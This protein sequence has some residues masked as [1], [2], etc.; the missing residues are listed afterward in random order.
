MTLY[1]PNGVTN[2]VCWVTVH[3]FT[4]DDIG[5]N[6]YKFYIQNGEPANYFN[7]TNSSGPTLEPSNTSIAFIT[8]NNTEVNIS[9]D[10]EPLTVLVNDTDNVTAGPWNPAG[11]NVTFWISYNES[12]LD[13]GNLT[14]TNSTGHASVEFDPGCSYSVGP[15]TWYA[16][17]T[18][19]YY[20]NNVTPYNL[21]VII[22]SDININLESPLGMEYMNGTNVTVRFNI[23]DDCGNLIDNA[24]VTINMTHEDTEQEFS[25]APVI[26]EEDEGGTA[27]WYNCT[28]NTSGMPP[29]EYTLTITANKTWYNF[30]N[31][32]D[33]YL[34]GFT[35]FFIETRPALSM[36]M[37][38]TSV[39]GFE[40]GG[41]GEHFNFSVLVTDDDGDSV[42]VSLYK[43]TWTGSGWS[44][45]TEVTS[46]LFCQNCNSSLVYY[47]EN[48]ETYN[49]AT[50]LG[51]W[52]FNFTAYDEAN[53]PRAGGATYYTQIMGYNYTVEKDDI[54]IF[55]TAGNGSFVWRNG[56][57]SESLS[58][59]INDTDL[60]DFL[61]FNDID[62][63]GIIWI[64]KNHTDFEV[65]DSTLSTDA[66]GIMSY[67]FNPDG[68][69]ESCD[70]DVGI[71]YWKMG[72]KDHSD[73]KDANSSVYTVEIWSY[74]NGTI[75]SPNGE[76]IRRGIDTV[77]VTFNIFDE[78]GNG[79]SPL[80]TTIIHLINQNEIYNISTGI[81]DHG[82][83][84]Y[85]Y[86]WDTTGK[87]LGEY[88]L[89][90]EVYKDY[91]IGINLSMGDSFFLGSA[92]QLQFPAS[93]WYYSDGDG[94]WGEDW[95][96]R[97]QYRDYEI[98]DTLNLSL[99]K[100]NT[101]NDEW[102]RLMTK[103]YTID[104]TAWSAIQYYEISDFTCGNV[105]PDG[106]ESQ[107][108]F[109]ATDQWG[110]MTESQTVNF[111]I[112]KDN[113]TFVYRA[114]G[115]SDIDREGSDTEMFAVLV[116]DYD[117]SNAPVSEN[118]SGIFWITTDGADYATYYTNETNSSGVLSYYFDPNC[119]FMYGEQHWKAGV[120]S[121]ECYFDINYSEF[122]FTLHGQLKNNILLPAYQHTYNV[123]DPVPIRL[124][125][126]TDCSAEGTVSGAYATIQ[127][128]SPYGSWQ[129]CTPVTNETSPNEGYYNCTWDSTDQRE[130]W[131]SIQLNS[132]KT[133]LNSNQ[134]Y[135]QDWFRLENLNATWSNQQATPS[136]DG[137][138]RLYNYSV[139]I[140]DPDSDLINCSLFINKYDGNGWVFKGNMTLYDP[141]GVTNQVCWVTVHDFTGDDIGPNTYKFYI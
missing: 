67:N 89:S 80:N 65:V 124:S 81:T 104:S 63:E 102:I 111:T 38:N 6:T 138:T 21:T 15:Q 113:A 9:G 57:D 27:G 79:V 123:T 76:P 133:Y 54:H 7:T 30:E 29:Q 23:T 130:G 35:G 28:F 129:S 106:W 52:Q 72:V 92:P 108:K 47:A 45:W 112:Y 11:V 44:A 20:E 34:A 12:Q 8:P 82:N 4:G 100:R 55:E 137:W 86:E 141:N 42:T 140:D 127:L 68:N 99:W 83:G 93:N 64:T 33:P 59:K 61:E 56:T 128:M 114:G 118:V 25:C 48:P 32:A 22:H 13:S 5:P 71:Q 131:W 88:N 107:Y 90:V 94:G 91:F 70:Y 49:P 1:D 16:M 116:R 139:E 50:D 132:S 85:T 74:L 36:P 73:Y 46:T 122:D 87:Y 69:T 117:R 105:T 101:P 95:T 10:T 41:W 2:Q 136:A 60:G 78:C 51:T 110:F 26:R 31:R 18:D 43:R 14:Q 120:W 77:N 53:S 62:S 125:A 135:L 19:G 115:D 17:V 75:D 103:N 37:I 24:D 121:D 3:D 96:F 109:N 58:A 39:D 66:N 126:T 98:N 40:T 84:T 134:T 119:T 97:V